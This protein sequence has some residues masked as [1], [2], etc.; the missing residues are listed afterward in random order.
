MT[1]LIAGNV[2]AALFAAASVIPLCAAAEQTAPDQKAVST[3]KTSRRYLV[4][5][6]TVKGNG[7]TGNLLSLPVIFTRTGEDKPLRI[8]ISDDSPEGSGPTFRSNVWLAAITAAML[9]ND[10]MRGVNITVESSG[11]IDGPSA[12]AV[13]CLAILSAIDNLPLP[14][15][16]AMTGTILPDGSVGVVG[17]VASK[18]RAA[19]KAGKKRVFI[20]AFQRFEKNEKKENVD[21]HRL[22]EQL[23]IKLHPVENIFEVYAILHN[24]TYQAPLY[25]NVRS[26]MKLSSATEDVLVK[27][28]GKYL[29]EVK[30]FAKNNPNRVKMSIMHDYKLSPELAERLYREGRLLP[31]AMQIFR[32]YNAWLA[33]Q[34]S[35][36]FTKQF[37]T[38]HNPD[39]KNIKILREFHYRK[40]LVQYRSALKE[41]FKKTADES[42]KRN[43]ALIKSIYQ[44]DKTS[45]YLP[46]AR[47]FTEITAQMEPVCTAPRLLAMYQRA[48]EAF[49]DSRTLNRAPMEK[50][51]EFWQQTVD[52]VTFFELCCLDSAPYAAFLKELC[53]TFPAMKANKYADDVEQL[54]YS[55]ARAVNNVA[56]GSVT[57]YLKLAPE[58]EKQ[59]IKQE[60]IDNPYFASYIEIADTAFGLHNELTER[61]DF[62][63]PA[64]HLQAALKAQVT[65][66]AMA[67]AH[68]ILYGPDQSYDFIPYLLRNARSSAIQCIKECIDTGIPCVSPIHD[69][70]MAEI[71]S[72]SH[73]AAVSALISYWRA[74]LHAK[75]LLMSFAKK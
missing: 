29:S 57:D 18:L 50:L 10:T 21:L 46:Y 47:E 12:G 67:A 60:V 31:A 51:A 59:K 40:L 45:G 16:F 13:T 27:T 2:F 7:K 53:A 61:T 33:Y 63:Y 38:K 6:L 11:D 71:A 52:S 44:N 41:Y 74:S 34:N 56:I 1:R 25:V 3:E 39:W 75:A 42:E 55:A 70:E 15:D 69:F 64:Y 22:A 66:Y 19:A 28:Y 72:S 36:N 4:P 32:T 9:R 49:P 35:E 62:T 73:S 14:D 5:C 23:K 54:F 24:K 17:A 26:A 48:F 58:N 68:L 65:T 43:N 37:L 8:M 30:K 20:P